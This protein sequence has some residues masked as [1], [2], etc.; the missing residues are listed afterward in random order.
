MERWN[1]V[2][3]AQQVAQELKIR[4]TDDLEVTLEDQ[5]AWLS[6]HRSAL[7]GKDIPALGKRIIHHR[8][9]RRKKV[10][11]EQF[12]VCMSRNTRASVSA[13]NKDNARYRRCRQQEAG[14]DGEED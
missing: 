3:E 10:L 4:E 2:D 5:V 7:A 11:T 8:R 13:R 9:Y 6:K 14:E 12:R 1:R